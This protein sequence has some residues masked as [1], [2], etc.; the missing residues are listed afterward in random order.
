ML[1]LRRRGEA[2]CLPFVYD[3]EQPERHAVITADGDIVSHTA[4]VPETLSIGED[5]TV[6]CDG[7]GGMAIA[8]PHR[9]NGYMSRLLQFWL[10]RM[11]ANDVP[12]SELSGNR[13]RYG[14]FG[15]ERAGREIVYSV[16]ERSATDASIDGDVRIYDGAEPDL[17]SIRLLHGRTA[18]N[19]A[20]TRTRTDR[21]R[22]ARSR[23]PP[24]L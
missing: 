10:E 2:A 18:P 12:P 4:C 24:L 16:T 7:I 22:T 21:L 19:R 3:R 5:A 1:R 11:A 15:W 6:E 17:E 20:G 13:E 14:H 23:D 8:K 9:G